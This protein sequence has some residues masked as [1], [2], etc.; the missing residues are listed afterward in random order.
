M[1]KKKALKNRIVIYQAKSG[2]LELRQ[3]L[4]KQTIWATQAEIA[5]LYGK[6]QS[7]ISRHIA[8]IFSDGEVNKKSNMQEMHI[9]NSGLCRLYESHEQ[10]ARSATWGHAQMVW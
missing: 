7:V 5:Q 4:Q 8:S 10:P 3:D 6:D 9:A 1:K 2:A